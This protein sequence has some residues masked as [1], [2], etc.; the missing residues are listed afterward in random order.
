VASSKSKEHF[1]GGGL[2]GFSPSSSGGAAKAS[3]ISIKLKSSRVLLSGERLWG[4]CDTSTGCVLG[5]GTVFVRGFQTDWRALLGSLCLAPLFLSLDQ[6]NHFGD[7]TC[8]V[9][10]LTSCRRLE[11][12]DCVALCHVLDLR[13]GDHNHLGQSRQGRDPIDNGGDVRMIENMTTRLPNFVSRRKARLHVAMG[14]K[15]TR[16]YYMP[17]V[18]RGPPDIFDYLFSVE[19]VSI[20]M[21]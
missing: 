10:C 1:G 16:P 11:G 3:A 5:R 20:S 9:F 15:G 2:L 4:G 7:R 14:S 19:L 13:Q 18:D 21:T 8:T 6:E 17:P 12:E